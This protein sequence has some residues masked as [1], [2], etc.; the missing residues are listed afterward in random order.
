MKRGPCSLLGFCRVIELSLVPSG[1]DGWFHPLPC[2]YTWRLAASISGACS[3]FLCTRRWQLHRVFAGHSV[4]LP[5]TASTSI[6]TVGLGIGLS[7]A[8]RETKREFM[9]GRRESRPWPGKLRQVASRGCVRTATSRRPNRRKCQTVFIHVAG[10][11]LI[12]NGDQAP[13][14]DETAVK[15]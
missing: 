5:R 14:A 4:E 6:G 3:S 2:R 15:Y 9:A 8:Q 7:F 11:S 12:P 10:K 13:G 1:T